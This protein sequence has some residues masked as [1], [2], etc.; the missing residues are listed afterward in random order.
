MLTFKGANGDILI[1]V[2]APVAAWL[3][4][5]GRTGMKLAFAWNVLGLCWQ[6]WWFALCGRPPVRGT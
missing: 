2:S 1:G 5:R 4:T 3:S 6:M